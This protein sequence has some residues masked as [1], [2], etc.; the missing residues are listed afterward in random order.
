MDVAT[1]L[2]SS[3]L[4]DEGIAIYLEWSSGV[5][6]VCDRGA[7][8]P[9]TAADLL[10]VLVALAVDAEEVDA[11][12]CWTMAEGLTFKLASGAAVGSSTNTVLV[13]GQALPEA[14]TD[15]ASLAATSA[16]AAVVVTAKVVC[17]VLSAII[18]PVTVALVGTV[19]VAVI[20]PGVFAVGVAV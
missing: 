18:C 7:A 15:A 6:T 1:S 17:I 19:T 5:S 9:P 2:N 20:V 12:S 11:G 16:A 13:A 8:I 10:D 3:R 4:V 14:A